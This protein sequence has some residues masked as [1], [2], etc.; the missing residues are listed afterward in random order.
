[1]LALVNNENITDVVIRFWQPSRNGREFNFYTI[2]LHNAR[3]VNIQAEMLNNKYRENMVHKEREHVSF[4]YQ[5]IVWTF[6]E[7]GISS[8]DDWEV[9]NV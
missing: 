8:E 1:M 7:G 2:Q 4:A 3:I 5:K 6:E 9:I